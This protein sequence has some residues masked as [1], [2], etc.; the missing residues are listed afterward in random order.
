MIVYDDDEKIWMKIQKKHL[1][2][3]FLEIAYYAMRKQFLC[4]FSFISALGTI[5]AHKIFDYF[6]L[7][8]YE[9]NSPNY[10]RQIAAGY[11]L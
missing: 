10:Q 6:P 1:L 7:E 2:E 11:I 4:I 8:N 9:T 5:Q 3:E